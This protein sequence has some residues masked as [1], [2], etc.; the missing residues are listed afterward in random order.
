MEPSL[1]VYLTPKQKRHVDSEKFKNTNGK[2][3]SGVAKCSKIETNFKR[4]KIH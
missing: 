4:Q 1:T 2:A 3:T